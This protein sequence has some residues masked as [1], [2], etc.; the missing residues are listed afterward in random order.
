MENNTSLGHPLLSCRCHTIVTAAKVGVF[1]YVP[2]HMWLVPLGELLAGDPES[3][4]A[5][6]RVLTSWRTKALARPGPVMSSAAWL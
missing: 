5:L 6:P 4:F 1:A 2:P 3:D